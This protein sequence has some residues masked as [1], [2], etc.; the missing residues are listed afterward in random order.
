MELVVCDHWRLFTLSHDAFG[1]EKTDFLSDTATELNLTDTAARRQYL[2]DTREIAEQRLAKGVFP[3][4]ICERFSARLDDLLVEILKH[5]LARHGVVAE[6]EFLIACVGGNGRRRPAPWSDVD[7][8]LVVDDSV[9][10]QV[11]AALDAFV[12]D[13]WDAGMEL[14]H[15]I[16]T[17][18]D[19]IRF[20][21][22]DIQ[23]A[24][25]LIDMRLLFGDQR[26]YHTLHDKLDRRIFRGRGEQ[27]IARCVA[28]RRDEWLARGDSVNQ[29]EPDLKKSP[30]GLRDLHLLRWIAYARYGDA[31]PATLL[32]FAALRTHELA[33]LQIADEFLTGLRL[34]LH[35]RSGMKQDI[36]T[37]ELQLELVKEKDPDVEDVGAAASASMREYF[38]RTS[39]VAETARRISES[40]R[41]TGL[42][43]RL[44][45]ALIRGTRLKGLRIQGG[46]I[47]LTR[48]A[49]QDL[50]GAPNTVME[51]FV[52]AAE[53]SGSLSP[54][55]RLAISRIVETLPDEPLLE[56][57][58]QFRKILRAGSGLPKTL[59][60]MH[61]TGVLEWILPPFAEIRCLM[62]F[63]HYH[64][65]TVDEH[66]LKTID[67]VLLL[68]DEDSPVGSA[69]RG[70][71]HKATLHLALLM[72]DIGKA[73]EGDHSV[74]GEALCEEIGIRLQMA[75]NK[76]QM[77][78][79]LVR[80][81]L[82]MPEMA[83][84]RDYTDAALIGEFA[85]M[86][87]SPERL[88]MLYVLSAGD[89]KA[90]G[91]G[92]WTEWKA[93]LLAD[94]YNRTMQIVSGRPSNHLEQERIQQIREHVREAIV[95]VEEGLD[96]EWPVWVDQ[97]LD[98]LPVFY[99]MTEEPEQIARDLDVIQQLA[100]SEVQINSSYDVESD[101]VTYRIFA[102]SCYEDGFF[103]KVA[104]ILSG[105]RNNIHT[106]VSCTA[107]DG[108][109]VARFAVTDNDFEGQVPQ[110]RM[111]NVT[112]A[113]TE[114][115]T[116]KQTVESVFR[117]SGLFQRT[118]KHRSMVAIEPKVCVD[119][120]CSDQYTVM[121]VFAIDAPGLLYTLSR[122]LYRHE[123]SVRL[124]RIGTKIDQ[125]VDVFH[126]TD[127]HGSKVTDPIRLEG[128]INDLLEGI[129]TLQDDTE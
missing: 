26:M 97:Q 17:P 18:A 24:T 117:K 112:A 108:T 128:I 99:L 64:S 15:S 46:V 100:E 116:G 114:V 95:P 121:D 105:L 91:P 74:I 111:Y 88:R 19:V 72:H 29:L 118:S 90:V 102:A 82:S 126:I 96:E 67:E 54:D 51:I 77:M 122:T 35:F 6:A 110:S 69:Y 32:Q 4:H 10:S 55:L 21:A 53:R 70:V 52:M 92:V 59:R 56:N 22:A 44:R 37:R 42:L 31:E 40:P 115:L 12:R 85:R 47:E 8:L 7:L 80:Q 62:Q 14:G 84:R 23:F 58:R 98:A 50:R 66:T 34:R 78:A 11:S 89:I 5:S 38:R 36:L 39:V 41:S 94:L 109:I 75:E 81:H 79:F 101:T 103:Y 2:A 27:F 13:C 73:R 86:V 16:R 25:S 60:Q 9:N 57:C 71:R 45:T 30:G 63:N 20:A 113:V 123:L 1:R 28:S 104:G 83:L 127:R 124:A 125:V 65:Y 76:K 61:E 3:N 48:E 93:E 49:R 68:Q 87:G 106:A 129:R 119:N 43:T 33:A 107:A 120:D